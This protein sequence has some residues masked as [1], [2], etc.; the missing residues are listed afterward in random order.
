MENI[1]EYIL[2]VLHDLNISYESLSHAPIMTVAEG[3][4]IAKSLGVISCKNLFLV[5]KQKEYFLYLLPGNKQLSAK[6]LAEQI[7][8]SHLSFASREEM[9]QLLS[10]SPGAVSIL[11]LI[12]D[13]KN[14]VRLLIDEDIMHMDYISCHPC[15]NTC[16]LRLKMVDI[17]NLLLPAIRHSEYKIVY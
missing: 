16:S 5:N 4:E 11:C 8:S 3:T 9:E 7:N 10:T 13:K 14:K 2:S 1:K 12:N 15:V 17:I 6:S